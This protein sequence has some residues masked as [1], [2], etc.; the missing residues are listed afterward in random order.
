MSPRGI[1]I[2]EVREQLF[3]AAE[4]VLVREG[5]GGLSGRAVTREAGV[6]TGVLHKHFTDLDEFL[7]EFVIDRAR[8]ALESVAGLLSHPGE[9]TVQGTLAEAAFSFGGHVLGMAGLVTSRPSLSARLQQAHDAGAPQLATIEEAFTA[10]LDAEKQLGR[11]AADAD[12]Q[13]L[14]L[15]LVAT[16]HHLRFTQGAGE[17]HMRQWVDRLVDALLAGVL[18]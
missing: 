12:T 11:V 15:A 3:Q 8:L 4:R 2:P 10:Y 5:P 9:G 13:V 1:A 16:V 6:A 18:S 7:A 17:P 14:A